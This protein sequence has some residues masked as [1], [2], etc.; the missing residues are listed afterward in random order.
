MGDVPVVET[1]AANAWLCRLAEWDELW[2]NPERYSV[3]VVMTPLAT[4]WRDSQ[5]PNADYTRLDRPLMMV[6]VPLSQVR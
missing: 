4:V 6:E 5:G 2:A 1:K 3:A